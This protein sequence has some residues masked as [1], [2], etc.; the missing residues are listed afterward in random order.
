MKFKCILEVPF[1]TYITVERD[2]L[3]DS[4]FDFL[5]SITDEEKAAAVVKCTDYYDLTDAIDF[6]WNN[7]TVNDIEII[8][9]DDD[10]IQFKLT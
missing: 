2:Q 3:P 10:E 4:K 9:D 1:T 7:P 8:D 6:K 5:K